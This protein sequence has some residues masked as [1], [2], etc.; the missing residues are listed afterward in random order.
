L[1]DEERRRRRGRPPASRPQAAA[2]TRRRRPHAPG[3]QMDRRGG[4]EVEGS[5]GRGGKLPA[6]SQILVLARTEQQHLR[7]VGAAP[8]RNP[9]CA[10]PFGAGQ[11]LSCGF[12][13][14]GGWNRWFA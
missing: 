11:A 8:G 13:K 7:R 3:G 14:I 6:L 4:E 9:P 1:A 2:G 5:A 10:E 12:K